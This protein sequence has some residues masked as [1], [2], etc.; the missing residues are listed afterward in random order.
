MV[1]A[2]LRAA[3][4]RPQWVGCDELALVADGE[5]QVVDDAQ[6]EGGVTALGVHEA[7]QGRIGVARLRAAAEAEAL[8]V[9]SCEREYT[10]ESGP[11]LLRRFVERFAALTALPTDTGEPT[12]PVEDGDGEGAGEEGDGEEGDGEEG[13]GEEG[14]GEA[15]SR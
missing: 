5:A 11:A 1:V 14:A 3:H 9:K 12:E 4:E 8:V 6:H 2:S 7:I 10:V 13:G 15:D